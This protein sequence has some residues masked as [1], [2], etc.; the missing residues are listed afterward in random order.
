MSDLAVG[1]LFAVLAVTVTAL[2]LVARQRDQAERA[3]DAWIQGF[4][5]LEKYGQGDNFDYDR[6]AALRIVA[7]TLPAK[8]GPAHLLDSADLYESVFH[9]KKA[10]SRRRST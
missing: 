8:Y 6:A 3:K 1:Y 5:W 7:E 9:R 10:E 2:F 4:F